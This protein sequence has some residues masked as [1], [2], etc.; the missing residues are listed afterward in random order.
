M[1]VPSTPIHSHA[2]QQK[3]QRLKNNEYIFQ[4]LNIFLE[5]SQE[6]TKAAVQKSTANFQ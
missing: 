6:R 4:A 5:N 1:I 2:T 3:K